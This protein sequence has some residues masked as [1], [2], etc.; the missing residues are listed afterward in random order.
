MVYQ[1][2][3]KVDTFIA[4][5]DAKLGTKNIKYSSYFSRLDLQTQLKLAET[6][7]YILT[8]Q[9]TAT[10][11]DEL[12]YAIY[13]NCFDI[14]TRQFLTTEVGLRNQF[15]KFLY[16]YNWSFFTNPINKNL[17]DQIEPLPVLGFPG[18]IAYEATKHTYSYPDSF[19]EETILRSLITSLWNSLYLEGAITLEER[20]NSLTNYL[21]YD[22]DYYVSLKNALLELNEEGNIN[23]RRWLITP[24]DIKDLEYKILFNNLA[25]VLYTEMI[26]TQKACNSNAAVQTKYKV[27]S[28]DPNYIYETLNLQLL[29]GNGAGTILFYY[30]AIVELLLDITVYL[31]DIKEKYSIVLLEKLSERDIPELTTI[32]ELYSEVLSIIYLLSAGDP[33][34][35][36][37][38][39]TDWINYVKV[40]ANLG[41]LDSYTPKLGIT[42]P[43]Q[44]SR[45]MKAN[46]TTNSSNTITNLLLHLPNNVTSKYIDLNIIYYTNNR[47][48][49]PLV[50]RCL[51]NS[52]IPIRVALNPNKLLNITVQALPT[53]KTGSIVAEVAGLQSNTVSYSI[54]NI[55]DLPYVAN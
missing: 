20:I 40:W 2:K 48:V 31:K 49:V 18:S 38:N 1:I 9:I 37:L 55:G 29:I 43:I 53:S 15:D 6:Q 44:Y 13:S 8:N 45:E 32:S 46:L 22:Y 28:R 3:Y 11:I 12:M 24:V 19:D 10:T 50:I 16:K 36:I 47:D 34:S 52:I 42:T 27:P 23:F 4:P 51:Y 21:K 35:T 5:S 17:L 39:L 14:V 7:V 54:K 33:S 25:S 30:A 26:N 41:K